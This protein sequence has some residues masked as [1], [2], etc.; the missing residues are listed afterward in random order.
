MTKLDRISSAL[1]WGID[2]PLPQP[3]GA[4]R[5][6]LQ[7]GGCPTCFQPMLQELESK[8]L[9]AVEAH[10]EYSERLADEVLFGTRRS[11]PQ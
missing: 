7:C 9:F 8:L 10:G 4:T 1:I 2:A 6:C 3:C 5:E 11:K